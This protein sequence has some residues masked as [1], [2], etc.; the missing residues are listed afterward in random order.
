VFDVSASRSVLCPHLHLSFVFW[1]PSC[2]I[3]LRISSPVLEPPIPFKTAHFL[4]S[5]F[6]ITKR[7]GS[8]G[9][10]ST[11]AS[12]HTQ[13]DVYPLLRFL[14]PMYPPSV[15]QG[16]ALFPLLSGKQATIWPVVHMNVSWNVPKRAWIHGLAWLNAPG[17]IRYFRELNC[18]NWHSSGKI[19]AD[20]RLSSHWRAWR[21]HNCGLLCRFL[22]RES[23]VSANC[24]A[25]L[26]RVEIEPRKKPDS[27]T[28]LHEVTMEKTS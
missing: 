1:L 3:A 4:H 2:S 7:W 28:R 22:Q 24:I 18:R 6:M 21:L 11:F 23:D 15:Y 14:S 27:F 16:Y 20:L 19:V 12:L 5:I 26:F 9:F 13:L 10:I 25:I 17:K 8:W